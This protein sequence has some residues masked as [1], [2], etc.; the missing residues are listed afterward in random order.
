MG[1]RRIIAEITFFE[2]KG[3]FVE[4]ALFPF[5]GL[6]QPENSTLGIQR[7]TLSA[8]LLL[9]AYLH[10]PVHEP[11]PKGEAHSREPL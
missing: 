8:Q 2:V 7:G 4:R 1:D 6:G 3:D 9:T 10:E 11:T 5:F